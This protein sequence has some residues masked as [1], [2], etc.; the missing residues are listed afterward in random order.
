MKYCSECGHPV[1]HRIPE[2]DDRLR[3]VCDHCGMVHYQNPNVVVGT[4]PV[5]QDKILLCKRAIEPQ[6]GL[7]TLPAG[8]LE[9]GETTLAGAERETFEEAG[10]KVVNGRLYRLF[11]IP[12]IDQVYLFYLAD[13]AEPEFSPGAESLETCLFSEADVPWHELAFPVIHDVL[14]EYFADR[15]RGEF[16]VRTGLPV[17]RPLAN[18]P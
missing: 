4:L 8:F 15:Q 14:K 5:W 11:D 16:P 9:N 6:Y 3:F 1:S 10:A 17:Y 2:M 12:F 7:W 18:E 13:L